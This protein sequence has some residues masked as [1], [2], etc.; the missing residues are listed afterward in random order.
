MESFPLAAI[1]TGQIFRAALMMPATGNAVR[2][3]FQRVKA[4]AQEKEV[5]PAKPG[6]KPTKTVDPNYELEAIKELIPHIS[7]P[8]GLEWIVA[9]KT[10]Y[11]SWMKAEKV[12]VVVPVLDTAI[13]AH[14][15]LSRFKEALPV[16]VS[17]KLHIVGFIV[18]NAKKVWVAYLDDE[19]EAKK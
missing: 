4:S 19:K 3:A 6:L 8:L 18:K 14:E 2:Q 9:P 15:V 5:T 10:A 12:G 1:G 17:S 11:D 16:A 13:A 7:K